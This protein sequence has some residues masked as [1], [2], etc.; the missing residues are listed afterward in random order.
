M[1]RITL[2]FILSCITS[3][4]VIAQTLRVD[5]FLQHEMKRRHITG[6]SVAVAQNGKIIFTKGYGLAN[7]ETGTLAVPQTVYKIASVSKEFIAAAIMLLVQDGKL[8]TDDPVGEYFD[9]LPE[10]WHAMTIRQLLTHT[11]GLPLDPPGFEPFKLV[12]DS[13]IVRNAC[14][15]PL[16]FAP[17]ERF[18]YSNTDYFVLAELIRRVSGMSWESF[19]EKR[20]FR[21]LQMN[22]TQITTTSAIIL[23][24]ASGY[25]HKGDTLENAENWIAVRPS[26]AFLSTVLDMTKWD[27]ALYTNSPLTAASKMAMWEPARFNNGSTLPYGFGWGL[28]PWMGHRR[29]FHDGGL[30][31]F[32]TDFERFIDDKLMIVVLSNDEN[33][34]ASGIALKIAAFFLKTKS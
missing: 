34:N 8:K 29:V 1:K 7:V 5:T 13:V 28:S 6:L 16:L 20:V 21:P 33:A 24:R 3:Q 25:V 23:N 15:T 32:S 27:Q 14:K 18:S 30:P 11:A 9:R 19:L 22:S 4:F 12:P 2:I 17:G 26:G 31:G 10:S